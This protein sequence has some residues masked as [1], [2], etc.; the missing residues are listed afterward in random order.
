MR[1]RPFVLFLSL[2]LTGL[3]LAAGCAREPE[4]EPP[5]S[6]LPV[7]VEKAVRAPFQPTLALLGTVRPA[8]TVEVTA[9]ARGRLA[10]PARF[11][12][13]LA[14]GAA[15]RAG[16]VL[17][18]FAAPE[19]ELS[20]AEAR[21]RLESAEADLARYQKAFE[22]GLIPAVQLDGY[23]SQK[24]IA[25]AQLAAARQQAARLALRSPLSG[26]LLVERIIPAGTEVE[27]G[28]PL[29]RVAAA[30]ALR[31]E[32]RA[33]AADLARLHPG[34]EIRLVPP[35][36]TGSAQPLGRGVIREVSPMVE[37]GG[38]VAWVA[39]VTDPTGLPAPGEGVEAQA[40]LDA[41]P[42]ALTVPEEALVLG[43]GGSALF[44]A[45]RTPGAV[46]NEGK[47]RAR[48]HAVETG[49]RGAGRV[50]ILRGLSPGEMVVIDGAA[51]LS[52]GTTIAPIEE[53][54]VVEPAPREPS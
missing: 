39:E 25:A 26:R 22:A 29:A 45:V 54:A 8:A 11:A 28:T 52:D 13:G 35:G 38:T 7:R 2:G 23:K 21:L 1:A 49:T 41:R 12:A 16:E 37:A 42:E 4:M 30:G 36:G 20:L 15:V 40:L 51:L 5:A 47:L 46:S 14:S 3:L 10:Y 6:E 24:A 53:P 48:R 34:L 33:A 50:E 17:A 27:A 31:I 9:P 19:S 32:G 18:L 43:E 44:V